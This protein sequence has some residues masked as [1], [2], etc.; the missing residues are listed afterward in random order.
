MTATHAPHDPAAEAAASRAA[1]LERDTTGHFW[2]KQ[3]LKPWTK[4]R[5]IF[6]Q[7]LEKCAQ[8][9]YDL[10]EDDANSLDD[11]EIVEKRALKTLDDARAA[12]PKSVPTSVKKNG[13]RAAGP[14]APVEVHLPG[15][16]TLINWHGFLASAS[17]VL[18]L[19]HHGPDDW[20]H[21][22]AEPGAWLQQIEDW[23]DQ[24]IDAPEVIEAVR[25]ACLLRTEHHQF[26]TMPRPEKSK[27]KIESGN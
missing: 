11:F 23:S 21:L 26:V 20:A 27:G 2:R 13:K 4:R 10:V 15:M 17:R 22:R 9:T 19:A 14:P 12:M 25:L 6:F 8:A 1:A 18:W 7:A 16:D 24:F 3:P 5:E